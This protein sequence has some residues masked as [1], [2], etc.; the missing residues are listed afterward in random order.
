MEGVDLAFDLVQRSEVDGRAL[1]VDT[2]VSHS[3][4]QL[5]IDSLAT[6]MMGTK[7]AILGKLHNKMSTMNQKPLDL[8]L[9]NNED[10]DLTTTLP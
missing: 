3:E 10:G 4:S 9:I 8:T 1:V 6:A 7:R 5:S 2:Y